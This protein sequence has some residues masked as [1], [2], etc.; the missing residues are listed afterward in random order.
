MVQA[1]NKTLHIQEP[2][3][4]YPKILRNILNFQSFPKFL[5]NHNSTFFF[6]YRLFISRYQH[7]PRSFNSS[8]QTSAAASLSTRSVG[9]VTENSYPENAGAAA[10]QDQ[11]SNSQMVEQNHMFIKHNS[12]NNQKPPRDPRK[13]LDEIENIDFV[14]DEEL[15]KELQQAAQ[16]SNLQAQRERENTNTTLNMVAEALNAVKTAIDTQTKDIQSV[17]QS[18]NASRSQSPTFDKMQDKR[19]GRGR[20]MSKTGV[21]TGAAAG[22]KHRTGT[23][24]F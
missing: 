7:K 12:T 10:T 2:G 22:V 17:I 6:I 4:F 18:Q 20:T 13:M 23:L 24:W 16:L 5:K 3:T 11:W 21:V 14:T 15:A 9:T 1:D 19:F 8:T